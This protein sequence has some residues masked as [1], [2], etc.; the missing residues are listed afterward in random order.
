[1][2]DLAP[3]VKEEKKAGKSCGWSYWQA[4]SLEELH[5]STVDAAILTVGVVHCQA[6]LFFVT[7]VSCCDIQ[8][9]YTINT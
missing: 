1:M 4:P 9:Y 3:M 6:R 2:Y 7:Y 8:K 5:D